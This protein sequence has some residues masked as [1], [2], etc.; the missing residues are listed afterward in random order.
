M[1]VGSIHVTISVE[2]PRGVV[3]VVDSGQPRI[4]GGI[5]SSAIATGT[6]EIKT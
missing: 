1:A 5:G 6:G 3:T 4:T 2:E